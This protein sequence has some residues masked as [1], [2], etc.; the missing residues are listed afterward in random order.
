MGVEVYMSINRWK[1]L[2][3]TILILC[4]VQ[5]SSEDDHLSSAFSPGL[6]PSTSVPVS[7]L[8]PGGGS[9]LKTVAANGSDNDVDIVG[10]FGHGQDA[11]FPEMP[12]GN[13]SC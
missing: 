13:I 1:L 8:L 6:I 7:D 5:S 9:P 12:G 10:I 3:A 2:W 4:T 11:V